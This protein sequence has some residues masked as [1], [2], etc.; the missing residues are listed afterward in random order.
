[1]TGY[2]DAHGHLG[3]YG[4][5]RIPR[6]GAGDLVRRMDALGVERL[7]LSS[8]AAFASDYRWGNDQTAAAAEAHPGRIFGYAVAN[9]HFCEEA[10][11]ELDR[12]LARPGFVGVKLHPTVHDY[13]L[14]GPG[15][16][17]AWEWAERRG[18]PVLTHFTLGDRRCGAEQVRQVLRR[19][20]GVRLLLAHLGGSGRD[21]LRELP[22]LAAE[23]PQVWFDTAGS[24]HYRGMIAR[25]V[26]AGLAPRLLYGS[27]MP[28]I[29]PGPQLGKIVFADIAEDARAAILGANARSFFGWKG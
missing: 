15:Y 10:G 28:F 22:I 11:A 2:I 12:C 7:V 24:R 27:D 8:H 18:L 19:H 29:D 9:P 16:R 1:M 17:S 6:A 20:S 4:P 23:L 26:A 14:D 5:F 21:V 3:E 13:P 25:L